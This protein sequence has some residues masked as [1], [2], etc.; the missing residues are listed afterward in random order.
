[1][2]YVDIAPNF[3][4]FEEPGIKYQGHYI[5][6]FTLEWRRQEELRYCGKLKVSFS[7]GGH[8]GQET[9]AENADLSQTLQMFEDPRDSTWPANI[10]FNTWRNLITSCLQGDEEIQELKAWDLCEKVRFVNNLNTPL[11]I[12]L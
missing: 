2:G 7:R 11:M 9:V 5:F 10:A 8:I 4:I 6:C 12:I 1:M 3:A